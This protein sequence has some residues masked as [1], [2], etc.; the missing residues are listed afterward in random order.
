M[1]SI[2]A[3]VAVVVVLSVWHLYNRRHAGWQASADG[4][5][6]ICCGYPLVAVA[7]YWLTTAPA[8]TTWEWVVG[9]AWALAAVMSFV[10]GFNA[11][12]AVTAEHARA[13]ARIET[14]DP[15]TNRIRH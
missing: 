15:A 5:F 1:L 7:T 2:I 4:R 13:A 11:L 12:N 9:N 10:V 3:A 14:I 6:F 8:A